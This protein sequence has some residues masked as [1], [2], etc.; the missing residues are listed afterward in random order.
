MISFYIL[1]E[2]F[3]LKERKELSVARVASTTK[4]EHSFAVHYLQ[5]FLKFL[6][7]APNE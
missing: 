6:K 7:S 5:R 4:K 2:R 3:F 1:F